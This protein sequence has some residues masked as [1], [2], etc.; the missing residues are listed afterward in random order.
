MLP[1]ESSLAQTG[2][3]ESSNRS[4]LGIEMTKAS[5]SGETELS[6][7]TSV[8]TL[9]GQ[10]K[11][12]NGFYLVGEIPI[13]T[14]DA[15]G[16]RNY[17]AQ[18]VLGNPYLG[19]RYEREGS[20]PVFILG[21]RPSIISEENDNEEAMLIGS[22]TEFQ[23]IESFFQKVTTVSFLGGYKYVS[24]EKF[25]VRFL[26]GSTI[27]LPSESYYDPEVFADGRVELIFTPERFNIGF[28]IGSKTLLT[29][30]ELDFSQANY[31]YFRFTMGYEL[32]QVTP[33]LHFTVPM[34]EDYI[35]G[36][37]QSVNHTWGVDVRVAL[38]KP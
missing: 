15:G 30:D 6:F 23:K 22:Y 27:W 17:D 2:L 29:E 24:S 13:S 1:L 31:Q 11:L 7:T 25:G 19:A 32:G 10:A 21:F 5:F 4:E 8:I 34:D 9:Q 28:G 20:S 35:L 16:G 12:P 3:L 33:G 18:T 36:F 37:K 38:D 26:L 14:L